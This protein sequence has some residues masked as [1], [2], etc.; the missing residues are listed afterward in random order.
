MIKNSCFDLQSINL[1]S[2]VNNYIFELCYLFFMLFSH[3]LAKLVHIVDFPFIMLFYIV[4]LD[5]P[6]FRFKSDVV[7]I[8]FS[9]F[10]KHVI[11][12]LTFTNFI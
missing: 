9:D 3:F 7:L 4:F 2:I 11:L 8:I 6:I 12:N 1:Y 10:S 5:F